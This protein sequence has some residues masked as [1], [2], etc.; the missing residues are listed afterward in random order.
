MHQKEQKKNKFTGLKVYCT[1]QS[2]WCMS[3]TLWTTENDIQ[4]NGYSY[5]YLSYYVNFF[6]I[7]CTGWWI[8]TWKL[9]NQPQWQWHLWNRIWYPVNRCGYCQ[10][11]F[12]TW[13]LFL[14]TLEKSHNSSMCCSSSC[15]LQLGKLGFLHFFPFSGCSYLKKKV[16]SIR[17]NRVEMKLI[18]CKYFPIVQ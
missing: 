11:F 12:V 13:I 15:A 3:Q 7:C 16:K 4:P 10:R 18:F 5:S 2:E 9:S 6:A 8:F 17:E 1:E 14:C